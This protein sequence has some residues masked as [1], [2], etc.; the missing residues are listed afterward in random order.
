MSAAFRKIKVAFEEL[1]GLLALRRPNEVEENEPT[2]ID[3]ITTND[4]DWID[5]LPNDQLG[6]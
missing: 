1:R 2:Y 3:S 4:Y 5:F 6:L